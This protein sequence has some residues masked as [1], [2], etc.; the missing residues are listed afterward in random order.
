MNIL[1]GVRF[2]DSHIQQD[3][4]VTKEDLELGVDHIITKGQ[5]QIIGD[6]IVEVDLNEIER[7]LLSFGVNKNA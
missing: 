5:K 3:I 2:V 6:L 4:K 7:A 1:C